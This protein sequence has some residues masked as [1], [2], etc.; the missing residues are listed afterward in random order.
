MIENDV[1][2]KHGRKRSRTVV[3]SNN[4]KKSASG[5]IHNNF[6]VYFWRL[7]NAKIISGANN[8]TCRSV[9]RKEISA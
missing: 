6:E 5:V 3:P 7:F 8:D 4:R 1:L 9:K 2:G